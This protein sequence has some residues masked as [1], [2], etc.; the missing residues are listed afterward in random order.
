MK[1][2]LRPAANL[3]SSIWSFKLSE[4]F[5]PVLNQERGQR[6]WHFDCAGC[7]REQVV[8]AS[9]LERKMSYKQL[10]QKNIRAFCWKVP[11]I[12]CRSTLKVQM[13]TARAMRALPHCC[14]NV[15][16]HHDSFTLMPLDSV[17]SASNFS[18]I[19]IEK[20]HKSVSCL[21]KTFFT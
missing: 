16:T 7:Y 3:C 20:R 19:N 10:K 13:L 17:I 8:Y 4:L 11:R 15:T 12:N 6:C 21:F 2:I 5:M 1:S 14:Y 9:I 18:G